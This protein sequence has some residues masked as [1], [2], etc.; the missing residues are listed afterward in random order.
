MRTGICSWPSGLAYAVGTGLATTLAHSWLPGLDSSDGRWKLVRRLNR[1]GIKKQKKH[2]LPDQGQKTAHHPS[3]RGACLARHAT[4]PPVRCAPP[5]QC[6]QTWHCTSWRRRWRWRMETGSVHVWLSM[7][8]PPH[9]SHARCAG[10]PLPPQGPCPWRRAS[11]CSRPWLPKQRQLP[12]HE[13]SRCAQTR[14]CAPSPPHP[15]APCVLAC[16][17]RACMLLVCLHACSLHLRAAAA[18]VLRVGCAMFSAAP[19]N[20]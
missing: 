10:L 12:P 11:P 15:P 2:G 9:T 3:V 13:R 6:C 18:S 20:C 5:T 16:S 7:C 17:Q 1:A 4:A 14:I 19:C 8:A